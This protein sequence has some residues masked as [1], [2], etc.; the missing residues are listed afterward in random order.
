MEEKVV[1]RYSII[2]DANIET[3]YP[4]NKT[5]LDILLKKIKSYNGK[6]TL[7]YMEKF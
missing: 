2:Q 6:K 7:L 1:R 3:R 4:S 5:E